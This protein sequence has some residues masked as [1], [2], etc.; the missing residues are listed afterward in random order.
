M[1]AVKV[2]GVK[3]LRVRDSL[4]RVWGLRFKVADVPASPSILSDFGTN[5]ANT[6][7]V[8]SYNGDDGRRHCVY[9]RGYDD[10]NDYLVGYNCVEPEQQELWI[11][12]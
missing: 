5:V 10:V 1:G 6:G 8:F 2:F 7:Y 9:L 4:H 12:N 11:E 3:G